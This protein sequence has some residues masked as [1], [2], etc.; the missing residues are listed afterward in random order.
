L[1]SLIASWFHVRGI[2]SSRSAKPFVHPPPSSHFTVLGYKQR[3]LLDVDWYFPYLEELVIIVGE[4]MPGL[5]DPILVTPRRPPFGSAG[6]FPDRIT[7]HFELS[8]S[9]TWEE[10]ERWTWDY[11]KEVA[12]EREDGGW[13]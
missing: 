13:G 4:V 10:A 1:S 6:W 9:T 12:K 11:V 2:I 8:E 7:G 5:S 3:I